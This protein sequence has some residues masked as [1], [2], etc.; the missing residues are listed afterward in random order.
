MNIWL[1]VRNDRFAASGSRSPLATASRALA[2]LVSATLALLL[3]GCAV[4]WVGSYDK[5]SVDRTTEISK[6]VLKVYQDL[7]ATPAD[8]RAAGVAGPM[9]TAHGNVESLMRL[10]L[11]REQARATN[12][13]SVTVAG[14]L[15]E[16]WQTFTISHRS[17]DSTAL[18]DAKLN[19]ERGILERHLS[20][21]F[22]AEEA[23]KLGGAKS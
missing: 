17:T 13:E 1:D 21:A 7:M 11:L 10:H 14:N 12:S 22:K 3:S 15:L 16:S 6:S 23:K 8:K 4:N 5:E 2:W 9:G 20:S 19:I 18:S